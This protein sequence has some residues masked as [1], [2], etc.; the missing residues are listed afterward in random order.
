MASYIAALSNNLMNSYIPS[1]PGITTPINSY[2]KALEQ[3]V[4]I[5]ADFPNATDHNEIEEAILSLINRS[6]QF[7]SQK[8]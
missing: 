7:A 1:P 8:K 3:I 6:A 4:N 2:E 5:T